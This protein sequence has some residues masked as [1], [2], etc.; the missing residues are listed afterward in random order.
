M[1]PLLLAFATISPTV[2]MTTSYLL[3][4]GYVGLLVPEVCQNFSLR[5]G[6]INSPDLST[7][8]PRPGPTLQPIHEVEKHIFTYEVGNLKL[9]DGELLNICVNATRLL[10]LPKLALRLIDDVVREECLLELFLALL[11]SADDSTSLP[12][13]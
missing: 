11:P 2:V 3:S 12:Y 4:F 10:Q 13:F 8:Q 9:E 7:I 5:H 6:F 1:W